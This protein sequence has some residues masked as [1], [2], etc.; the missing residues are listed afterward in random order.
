VLHCL[1]R[2]RKKVAGEPRDQR[3]DARMLKTEG[4]SEV[5]VAELEE[6]EVGEGHVVH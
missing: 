3:R 4:M 6:G 2:L 5:W 1:S